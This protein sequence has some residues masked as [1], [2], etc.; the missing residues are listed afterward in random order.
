MFKF[1]HNNNY[2]WYEASL[3][4]LD[5]ET[6]YDLAVKMSNG[7]KKARE[8][9]IRANIRFAIK[10]ARQYSGYNLD[11]D[12]LVSVAVT[13]LVNAV[14]HFKADRNARIIT[15][16]VWWIRAE[17]KKIR[18]N[19]DEPK[20][21]SCSEAMERFMMK[22]ADEESLSPEENAMRSCFMDEFYKNVR[23]LPAEERTILMMHNGLCGYSKLNYTEIGKCYGKT[24]QWAWLKAQSA[25][26]TIANKMDDWRA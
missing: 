14:D 3:D 2:F 10:V 12:D 25:E 1:P 5:R 21:E 18:H 15:C 22:Q 6:E 19:D 17:F 7:D 11:Y 16:A 4:P 20:V 26:Q 13:G 23:T 24:K 8:T 9:L